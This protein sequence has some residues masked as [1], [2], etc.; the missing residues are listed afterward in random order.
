[1]PDPV[2]P[3]LLKF[4][5]NEIDFGF[6]VLQTYVLAGEKEHAD[7]SLGNAETAYGTAKEYL[8]RVPHGEVPHLRIR[9]SELGEAIRRVKSGEM[10]K[11]NR[12]PVD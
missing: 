5:E 1:L 12:H 9:L 10:L 8:T 2:H 11:L 6:T 3:E 7:Q 4:I